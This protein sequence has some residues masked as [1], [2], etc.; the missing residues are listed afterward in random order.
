MSNNTRPIGPVAF[1]PQYAIRE[2]SDETLIR[3]S[4]VEEG[5]LAAGI[6]L[7]RSFTGSLFIQIPLEEYAD[8]LFAMSTGTS[9]EEPLAALERRLGMDGATLGDRLLGRKWG[10]R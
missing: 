1:V 2:L 6:P 3:M 4:A 5:M 8:V 7:P 9:V 10:E